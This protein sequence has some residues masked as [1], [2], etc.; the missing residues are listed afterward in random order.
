MVKEITVINYIRKAGEPLE[1]ERK[2]EDVPPEEQKEIS[3]KMTDTFMGAA[4][5]TRVHKDKTA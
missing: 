5:Y 2:W 4:G 3:E 1:A